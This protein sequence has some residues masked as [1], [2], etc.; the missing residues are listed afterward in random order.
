MWHFYIYPISTLAHGLVLG[1]IYSGVTSLQIIQ[2]VS[3]LHSSQGNPWS[4]I[5]VLISFQSSSLQFLLPYFLHGIRAR[6]APLVLPQPSPRS[7]FTSGRHYPAAARFSL[8]L[9]CHLLRASLHLPPLF[10]TTSSAWTCAAAA[11]EG[12]DLLPICAE[13]LSAI[14]LR[15]ICP[16]IFFLELLLKASRPGR[17]FARHTKLLWT[18]AILSW[19]C[20]CCPRVLPRNSVPLLSPVSLGIV[21]LHFISFYLQKSL[22]TTVLSL[23]LPLKGWK[24]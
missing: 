11:L 23:G 15:Y 1:P 8:C 10:Y 4:F 13:I 22:F 17:T 6:F 19:I 2:L 16:T 5:L 18:C 14:L 7:P 12:A 21:A 24:T 20:P 9:P 3:C